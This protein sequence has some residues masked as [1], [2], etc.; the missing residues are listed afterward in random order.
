MRMFDGDF[1]KGLKAEGEGRLKLGPG[2]KLW[3]GSEEMREYLSVS[4]VGLEGRGMCMRG[5]LGIVDV[6]GDTVIVEM[7]KHC[8]WDCKCEY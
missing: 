5:V 6:V 1:M 4:V 7:R 3:F 8:C 2:R